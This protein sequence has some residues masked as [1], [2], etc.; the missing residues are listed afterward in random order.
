[1]NPDKIPDLHWQLA[2]TYHTTNVGQL[3]FQTPD[4]STYGVDVDTINH[5]GGN[6]YKSLCGTTLNTDTSTLQSNNYPIAYFDT[7]ISNK[8]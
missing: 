8:V 5:A 1:M 3:G 4:I 2:S 7:L 6:K